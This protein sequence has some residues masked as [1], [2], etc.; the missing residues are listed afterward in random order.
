M[1]GALLHLSEVFGAIH[2]FQNEAFRCQSHSHYHNGALIH[3]VACLQ[4]ALV[5]DR[6]TKENEYHLRVKM[7]AF[8]LL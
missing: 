6:E 8:T 1:D 7:S 3:S 2:V 4:A 5:C